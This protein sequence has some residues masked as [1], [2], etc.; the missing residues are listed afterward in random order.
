LINSRPCRTEKAKAHREFSSI[1]NQP[2]TIAEVFRGLFFV[3]RKYGPIVAP[4]EVRTM[5][6]HFGTI[7]SCY[8]A[9]N[10]ER[11]ALNL[12]EGVIVEFEMYDEGQ[13]AF[14]VSTPYRLTAYRTW[15]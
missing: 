13:A 6:C 1:L 15:S 11:A 8:T 5:M 4:E 12:N 3:E 2:V 10:V 9:S 14:A 7:T